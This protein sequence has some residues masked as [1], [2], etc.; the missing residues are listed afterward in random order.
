MARRIGW[1]LWL[2]KLVM[3]ASLAA[4]ALAFAP[5][6]LFLKA[7]ANTSST[8]IPALIAAAAKVNARFLLSLQANRHFEKH[9][10]R[11]ARFVSAGFFVKTD[12]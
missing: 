6:P 1:T 3:T 10:T 8:Q 7:T 4:L 5:Y 11:W 9:K 2:T 12:L